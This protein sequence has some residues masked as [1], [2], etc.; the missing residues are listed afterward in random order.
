MKGRKINEG[1]IKFVRNIRAPPR[2]IV[3]CV[4][5]TYMISDLG[6]GTISCNEF[7]GELTLSILEPYWGSSKVRTSACTRNEGSND[8]GAV[9]DHSCCDGKVSPEW[10]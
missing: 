8:E 9:K 1:K 3:K 2:E 7:V 6:V 5:M 4:S 10:T